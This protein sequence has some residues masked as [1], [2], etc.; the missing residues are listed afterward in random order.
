MAVLAFA[1]VEKLESLLNKDREFRIF[2]PRPR[3]AGA[4]VLVIFAVAALFVSQPDLETK[5]AMYEKDLNK[6]LNSRDYHIDPAELLDLMHNIRIRMVILDVRSESDYNIF[7]LVD[8]VHLPREQFASPRVRQLAPE[9]V[10]VVMSNDEETAELAW[11]YLTAQGGINLYILEGGINHWLEIY[12]GATA[13][14]LESGAPG[15]ERLRFT[16][17]DVLGSEISAARPQLDQVPER[18]YTP[19]VKVLKPV[20]M[21][22]GGCG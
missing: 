8:A 17:P 6:R 9:A 12:G 16:F 4:V 19:K 14:L 11:K 2:T 3:L 18:E 10:K 15:V 5:L 22:G 21:E 20:A 7:H 1:G 13:E